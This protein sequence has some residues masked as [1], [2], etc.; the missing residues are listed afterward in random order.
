MKGD[1]K[2]GNSKESDSISNLRSD[3]IESFGRNCV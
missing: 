3:P 1:K 2:K